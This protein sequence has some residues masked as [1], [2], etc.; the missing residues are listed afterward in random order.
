MPYGDVL[1][2]LM[3]GPSQEIVRVTIPEGLSRR[4][5]TPLVARAGVSGDYLRA[6][7]ARR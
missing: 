7:A 4:E 3:A 1:D 5:I 2:R 6:S